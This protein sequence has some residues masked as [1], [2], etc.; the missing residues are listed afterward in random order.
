MNKIKDFNDELLA[1]MH[2]VKQKRI[3]LNYSYADM[4]KLTGI[5]RS[6]L[7][8]YENGTTKNIPLSIVGILANALDTTPAWIMG[9]TINDKKEPADKLDELKMKLLDSVKDFS[10]E[11]LEKLLEFAEIYEASLRAKAEK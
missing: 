2:R 4:E 10:T 7:Q 3:E 8:R 5:P 9:W 1:I 11:Q 6:T